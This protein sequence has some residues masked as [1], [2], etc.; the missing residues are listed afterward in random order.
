ME[1]GVRGNL[2]RSKILR[3]IIYLIGIYLGFNIYYVFSYILV[4][5]CL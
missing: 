1:M 3:E 2:V 5:Y 4:I